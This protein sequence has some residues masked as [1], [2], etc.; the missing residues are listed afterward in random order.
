MSYIPHNVEDRE[1]MLRSIGV[2]SVE[3]LLREIPRSLR[4][5]GTLPLPPPL[6]QME[7]ERELAGIAAENGAALACDSFLG[8]GVYDHYVPA[9]VGATAARP[10]FYSA[11]TPYQAEVSQGTL[12]V[13]FE[14]QSLI[15]RLTGMPLVNASLYDGATALV[16]AIWM[17]S[18]ERS[19]RSEILI[20]RALRPSYRGVLCS[21]LAVSGLRLREF[22]FG[23]EGTTDLSRLKQMVSSETAAVVVES[24]NVFGLLEETEEAG[25][26]AHEAGALF[27]QVFD[28]VSLA[29]VRT[30]AEAGADIAVG[31]GQSLGSPPN[32]GGPLLGLFAARAEFLRRMPGRLSGMTED[33]KG[34]RAFTLT[35]QTREQHI[36][37]EKA[38]SNICTNQGLVALA[39]AVHL[40]SLGPVGLRRAALLS[41]ERA[42][43][44]RKLLRESGAAFPFD[45]PFFREFVVRFPE[46]SLERGLVRHL[47]DH[48]VIPGIPLEKAYPEM[49]G[50]LLVAVTEKRSRESI[51]R[52]ADLVRDF[53]DARGK[54]APPDA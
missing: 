20:A 29:I 49:R 19:G 15:S 45:G 7:T 16:E 44:L 35:L 52:Y 38:T 26:I 3:D 33:A 30:P 42:L 2:S 4:F 32:F 12:Q 9:L 5:E 37:R 50:C 34:A 28:P 18:G 48:R 10:E 1:K 36:R 17:A 51:R 41:Q 13:I 24:P 22:P 6:S 54:G 40:S 11:Y 23:K 14:F 8:G 43:E 31:E 53:A 25:R 39:A 21:H 27:I 46:E 47:L